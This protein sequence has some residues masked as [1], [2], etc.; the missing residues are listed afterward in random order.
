[1]ALPNPRRI[2]ASFRTDEE[3]RK[4]SRHAISYSDCVVLTDWF[5]GLVVALGSNTNAVIAQFFNLIGFLGSC[6]LF[7]V[8]AQRLSGWKGLI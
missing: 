7:S 2:F 4:Y 8:W 5:P 3:E 6:L 1:M